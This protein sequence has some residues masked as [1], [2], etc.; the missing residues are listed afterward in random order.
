MESTYVVVRSPDDLLHYGVHGMK[1]GIRRYQN[2]DGSLTKLGRVRY[3][4]SEERYHKALE[5]ADSKWINKNYNKIQK[6]AEKTVRREM[7][8]Y[9]KQLRREIPA[10]NKN[11]KL[12]LTYANAYNQKMASLLNEKMSNIESPSGRVVRFVARRGAMGV[13]LALADSGFDMSSVS[14][15][16]YA[17]G[18]KAYSSDSLSVEELKSKR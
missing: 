8:A 15:G 18:R 9:S 10:L 12:S 1:W 13:H 14:K 2:P 3:L 17:S 4:G 5:R 6:K 16:V 11:G 7:T